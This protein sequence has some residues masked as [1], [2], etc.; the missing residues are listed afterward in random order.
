LWNCPFN[1]I[2]EYT[3][4]VLYLIQERIFFAADPALG[5]RGRGGSQ[6]APAAVATTTALAHNGARGAGG[7]AERGARIPRTPR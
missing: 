4:Y 7:G 5:C 6:G 2:T 3:E 1:A